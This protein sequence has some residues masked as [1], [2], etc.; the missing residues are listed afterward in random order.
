M[1]AT[2]ELHV[3]I[4]VFIFRQGLCNAGVLYTEVVI[5]FT[6]HTLHHRAW[7]WS[8]FQKHWR[9]SASQ[10]IFF[11]PAKLNNF[12]DE[13]IFDYKTFSV[14]QSKNLLD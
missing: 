10:R 7:H 11:H 14:A 8:H 3:L 2:D 12:E 6:R 13:K 5:T 9:L 4:S 1:L